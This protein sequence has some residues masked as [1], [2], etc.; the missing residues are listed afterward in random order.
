MAAR[1]VEDGGKE[2]KE[3]F[4]KKPSLR[5]IAREGVLENYML[6]VSLHD[7]GPSERQCA[8]VTSSKIKSTWVPF[9]RSSN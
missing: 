7:V 2:G 8:L 6:K 3:G 5:N 9:K 4:S 1:G